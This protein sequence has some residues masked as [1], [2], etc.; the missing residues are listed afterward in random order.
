MTRP[1]RSMPTC[2]W[3]HQ[4]VRTAAVVGLYVTLGLALAVSLG[5]LLV[6]ALDRPVV[7]QR[8]VSGECAWVQVYTPADKARGYSC[9]KL[10]ERYAVLQVE[11]N[12]GK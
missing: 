5:Y 10:P 2:S 7:Y 4:Y 8:A 3:L 1:I 11:E 9:A 6:E 12:W